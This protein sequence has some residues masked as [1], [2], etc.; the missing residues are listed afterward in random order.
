[1]TNSRTKGRAGEQ[2]VVRIL[3]DELGL[4]IN[5]NWQAQ[6]AQ[7]GADILA[8]PGWAIE[9]KR[10][11]VFSN[12]WWPQAVRQAE[13]VG[14]RPALVYRL[15]RKPWRVRCCVSAVNVEPSCGHHFQI[16][17]D[18]LDWITLVR[19]EISSRE[20]ANADYKTD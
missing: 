8:V 18:L 12:E 4:P 14:T 7:G 9:V 5:R 2:E 20:L 1:M 15:D 17:M 19:E 16:E 13:L 6:C 10:Q 3:R 11:K